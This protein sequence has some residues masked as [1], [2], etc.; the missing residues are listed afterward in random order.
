MTTGL[1]ILAILIVLYAALAVKLGR[2][3][4]TMPMVFVAVGFILGPGG[5]NLLP[6]SPQT[7]TV[8]M[9]TEITLALLLFADA[10]T[11]K[12]EQ[13]RDDAG[14]SAR[15]LTIGLLLTIACGAVVALML[16]PHE[17][18]AFA[19]LLGA[20]LAPTDAALGLPIFN[21]PRVPVRIRR[22]L[23]IESGLNDG[24]ATPF[25]LLFLAFAAATEGQASGGWLTTALSEIALAILAGAAIG[26]IGGWLLPQ[27]TRR[28]W[29]SGGAEQL[30][31]LGLAFAAYFGSLAIGG[32]G[33][34]AAFVGGIVFRAV[35][36]SQFVEPTEFT[37]TFGTFLSLLV[38]GIFG[39]VLVSAVL[40]NMTD[41]HSILY[42]ILSLTVVR[43]APVALA[44]RGVGLRR[45]T[46]ALMGWFGPRGLASVV[47]TL[48]A[49]EQFQEVS[50]PVDTLIAAATWTILLSV[51]LH[52]LSATPLSAWY[53]RRLEAAKEP[54][55]ELAGMS[56]L[57]QRRSVLAGPPKR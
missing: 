26:A 37:E 16:N 46:V 10:S 27:T 3:S 5:A 15:L 4:I 1:A 12:L 25:V 44:L 52:G 47:F 31:I 28:G 21:N 20:I 34:I 23:N 7:E 45:D 55:V 50:R 35:S 54:P 2:W 48:I 38:W 13:V 17:G 39:A 22:A 24:I 11:L 9:L 41:W 42:A 36:R 40:D 29:T 6:I 30:A 43:M 8:K 57:R 18:L 32:N 53:A 51:V 49:L 56:E 19:C 33:F 14:L